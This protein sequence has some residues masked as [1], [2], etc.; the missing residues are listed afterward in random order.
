VLPVWELDGILP[1]DRGLVSTPQREHQEFWGERPTAGP[2]FVCGGRGVDRIKLQKTIR[3]LAEP[4][5]AQLGFELVAVEWLGGDGAAVLRVSI[6][7]AGG[8]SADDCALISDALSPLL[9]AED[10][11]QSRYNLEVSSPGIERP[12]QT[13]ADFQR[14]LGFKIKVRLTE[15]HPRR[16]FQG[17]LQAYDGDTF[18]VV[19]DGEE[20]TLSID[21]VERANLVLTLSEYQQLSGG[22]R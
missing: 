15:G 13:D 1:S 16:R 8:I 7:S 6:D 3:T 19:V 14:F 9:D 5:V 17:D 18:V 10:P 22:S 21:A 2:L 4:T 12:V 11:V 20:H